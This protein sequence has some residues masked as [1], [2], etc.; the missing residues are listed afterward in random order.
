MLL[1]ARSCGIDS[2]LP[3][4]KSQSL[5]GLTFEESIMKTGSEKKQFVG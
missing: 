5:P 1:W 4:S 2:K 3:F